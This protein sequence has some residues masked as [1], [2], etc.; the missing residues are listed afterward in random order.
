MKLVRFCSSPTYII[1]RTVMDM[2]IYKRRSGLTRA[3]DFW[4]IREELR[5]RGGALK[6]SSYWGFGLDARNEKFKNWWSIRFKCAIALANGAYLFRQSEVVPNFAHKFYTAGDRQPHK[7]NHFAVVS[8]MLSFAD[9]F[10]PG[11]CFVSYFQL[12]EAFLLSSV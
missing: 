9:Y 11:V 1:P 10:F 12:C 7:L 8:K 5:H 6:F 3:S 2:A 4:S